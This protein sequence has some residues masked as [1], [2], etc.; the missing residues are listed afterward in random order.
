MRLIPEID[1]VDIS[2]AP[3]EVETG[4]DRRTIVLVVDDERLIADTLSEILSLNGYTTLT[5]Y[6]GVTALDI[7][8]VVPPDVL[9]SDVMMPGLS[10]V[11]LA[12]QILHEVPDC[13]IL[14][15]SGQASSANLLEN[16]RIRGHNFTL[17][18]KPVHP[19]EILLRVRELLRKSS[20]QDQ[21]LT[22]QH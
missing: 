19:T 3:S 18:T 11:E 8:R 13:R 12:I 1:I 21:S 20:R 2:E 4:G 5:A 9:L 10:G 6:N 15:S 7:A 16:A 14:L 22:L 17:L